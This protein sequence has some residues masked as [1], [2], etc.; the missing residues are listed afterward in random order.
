[1]RDKRITTVI[2][3]APFT[4]DHD[5]QGRTGDTRTGIQILPLPQTRGV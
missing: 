1:M 4:E 2:L 5:P 3:D